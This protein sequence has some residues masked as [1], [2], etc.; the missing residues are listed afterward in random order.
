MIVIVIAIIIGWETGR[1]G[2][3]LVFGCGWPCRGVPIIGCGRH[4]DRHAS[5]AEHRRCRHAD[6]RR[7]LDC[8]GDQDHQNHQAGQNVSHS[9][10]LHRCDTLK[11][12]E[13][14]QRRIHNDR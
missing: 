10:L 14:T 12:V 4:D 13:T 6:A 9:F 1:L 8:C 7:D 11:I 5:A 3:R 2:G